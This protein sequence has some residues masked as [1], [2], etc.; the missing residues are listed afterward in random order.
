MHGAWWKVRQELGVTLCCVLPA[1]PRDSPQDQVQ[2][3]QDGSIKAMSR[4][5][6]RKREKPGVSHPEHW[7]GQGD[8]AVHHAPLIHT[9]RAAA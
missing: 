5:D 2:E 6:G 7:P 3:G 9:L 4:V 1:V 8:K